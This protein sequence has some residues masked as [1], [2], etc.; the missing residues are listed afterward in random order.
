V[1]CTFENNSKLDD[2]EQQ[3][4]EEEGDDGTDFDA[5]I[6]DYDAHASSGT[7]SV[8]NHPEQQSF[9]SGERTHGEDW[10]HIQPQRIAKRSSVFR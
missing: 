8:Y 5:S 6:S 1:I 4:Q 10:P 2:E 3:L 9:I 7:T